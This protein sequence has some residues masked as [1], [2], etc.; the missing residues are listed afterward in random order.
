MEFEMSAKC[1]RRL[2]ILG[3]GDSITF[4]SNVGGFRSLSGAVS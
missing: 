2:I 1:S 4:G 3:N